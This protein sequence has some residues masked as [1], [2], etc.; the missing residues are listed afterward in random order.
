MNGSILN[1]LCTTLSLVRSVVWAHFERA[2]L[3]FVVPGGKKIVKKAIGDLCKIS[4]R[5]NFF[6]VKI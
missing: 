1:F 4:D 5:Y 3:Y 2:L 6:N